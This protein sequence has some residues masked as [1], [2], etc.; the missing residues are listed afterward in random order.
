VPGLPTVALAGFVLT[1][2]CAPAVSD[3]DT[4]AASAYLGEPAFRR[5]RMAAALVNPANLYGRQRLAH[6]AS[7][8]PGDWDA[9][10]EWN[11]PVEVI[12]ADQLRA[13]GGDL[14]V[15]LSPRATPLAMPAMPSAAEDPALLALG[16]AA[17]ERYPAQ[18]APYLGVAL[19]SPDAAARYGLWIDGAL[20]VGGLV[21]ARMADG[22]GAVAMTC[23]TCH[24]GRGAAGT[25][26]PGLP[27]RD[28][29]LGR[30]ILDAQGVPAALSSAD[31]MAAWGAGRLD[32]STTIGDEPARI[33]DLRAVRWQS[34]LHHDATLRGADL[35]TLAIRIETLLVTSGGEAVRPPRLIAL[36]LAAYVRSLGTA[37]P[38]AEVAGRAAPRGAAIFARACSA[39]HVPPALTG[40]P[41]PLAEIG[42]EPTL[43]LSPSRGTGTY[44]V[45]SL[46][47][48]GTR[49][50]LLHDGTLP[51][52]EALFAPARLTDSFVRLHGHG[53]VP[54]HLY[55]LDLPEADRRDLIDYLRRL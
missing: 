43:G 28:L 50:P 23:S 19:V 51:S 14:A 46:H 47:G 49:G 41:V 2:A 30:A 15:A 35:V 9:L 16:R 10:P 20:G 6:Y 33:P 40:D 32:V 53:A 24:T 1:M 38:R 45:P 55:G 3:G 39:C 11:P 26:V 5:A 34:F 8:H 18:I 29:D 42:T 17:F 22:S 4:A 13:G 36:A 27:N 37:L 21:R 48:V 31:P 7:G 25:L 54:G 52:L 44:R 12:G